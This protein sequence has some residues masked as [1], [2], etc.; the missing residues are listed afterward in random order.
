MTV[1]NFG[2][3]NLDHSYRVPHLPEP[4]ETLTALSLHSG[5]GGKGANQSVAAARAGA[6]VMHIGMVGPDGAGRDALGRFGVDVC[7]V[8]TGEQVTGH[9]C[10]YVDDAGENL[11]VILPGANRE[12][13]LNR[14]ESAL[15]QAKPGDYFLLQ[16]EATLGEDAAKL[17]RE[18]G[19]FVVYSAAPFDAAH[20]GAMLPL[21]DLLVMNAVE[22]GQ[23]VAHLGLPVEELEVPHLLVTRGAEGAIWHAR[24]AAAYVA[25]AFRVDP[26][27]TTGAGD[28]FIGTVIAGLDQGLDI[29]GALRLGSAAAALQV[30]RLGTAEAMP[31]RDE[32]EAFLVSR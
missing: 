18:A 28:C 30:T 10:I 26:V 2:S 16:N 32:V 31:T 21:V 24:G 6:R 1:F 9:A 12:Q 20:A 7:H 15:T 8:G 25:P 19:C 5:L 13:S 4:G 29:P 11:I 3:I 27:D 22:A 14:V 23:M 17:A